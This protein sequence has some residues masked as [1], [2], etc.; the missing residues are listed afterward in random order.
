[1]K[2]LLRMTQE[3]HERFKVRALVA[4]Q[5]LCE[6]IRERCDGQDGG[7]QALHGRVEGEGRVLQEASEVGPQ[8]PVVSVASECAAKTLCP[9]CKRIGSPSCDDCVAVNGPGV[10][11]EASEDEQARKISGSDADAQGSSS[12]SQ[13]T[14]TVKAPSLI[15]HIG[16]SRTLETG[17]RLL[18]QQRQRH[19]VSDRPKSPVT[20]CE[21]CRQVNK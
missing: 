12:A 21:P 15:A 9:R 8:E 5:S 7:I 1:M 14:E 18:A 17:G 3:E 20:L 6:W 4:G 13:A 16:N 10:A 11:Q 19:Q 2:I